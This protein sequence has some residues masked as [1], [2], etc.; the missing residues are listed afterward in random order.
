M[1]ARTFIFSVSARSLYNFSNLKLC[2][3][4][5]EGSLTLGASICSVM[6][7]NGINP[8]LSTVTAGLLGSLAGLITAFLHT[9]LKIQDILAGILTMISL[10]SINI[11]IMG[12]SNIS[13]L[14]KNTIFS[15][16]S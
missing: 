7:I 16:S 15:N 9:K 10:Y 12:K 1:F 6:L 5:A 2:R 14:G 4:T 8:I 13:L 11:R 3:L